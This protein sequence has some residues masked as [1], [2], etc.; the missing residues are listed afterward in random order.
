MRRH[1]VLLIFR[2]VLEEAIHIAN[3]IIV[4][5]L[6]PDDD[7]SDVRYSSHPRK[8]SAPGPDPRTILAK[9]T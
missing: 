4:L 1:T 3:R 6:P 9:L 5:S 7:P 8:L 2:A